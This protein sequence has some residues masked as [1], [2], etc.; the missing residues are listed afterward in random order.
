VEDLQTTVD[1]TGLSQGRHLIFVE[2]KDAEDHWGVPSAVFLDIAEVPYAPDLAP[3]QSNGQAA[4][5]YSANYSLTLT[6]LGTLSDSFDLQFSGNTWEISAQPNPAGPLGSG[7]SQEISVQVTI[8]SDASPGSSDTATITAISQGD[9][10]KTA[11][12]TVTTAAVEPFGVALTPNYAE[13][14]GFPG[15]KVYYNLLLTNTGALE[16]QF[17]AQLGNHAWE[18]II[19]APGEPLG[20][21]QSATVIVTVTLPGDVTFGA[22]DTVQVSFT[23]QGNP[24]KSASASLKTTAGEPVGFLPVTYR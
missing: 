5:G 1:T 8:P 19:Q 14:L 24:S 2:S 9:T 7:E 20:P 13:D 17:T 3:D 23:S 15:H 21:G 18:T 22:S 11:S 12:A 4:P 16:D 10:S 6:N